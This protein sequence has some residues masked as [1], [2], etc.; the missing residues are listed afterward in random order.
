MML[1][2]GHAERALHERIALHVVNVL[3]SKGFADIRAVCGEHPQPE[4]IKGSASEE[5]HLP[6][7][8]AVGSGHFVI[9]IET[10]S[11]LAT[12]ETDARWRA[13]A[14]AVD[15]GTFAEFIAVVPDSELDLA[16]SRAEALGVKA[17]ILTV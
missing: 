15:D 9:C 17:K 2:E 13:F 7:I 16:N 6:D 5:S 8:T 4:A 1:P 12:A 10:P 14:Q 11:T 3:E